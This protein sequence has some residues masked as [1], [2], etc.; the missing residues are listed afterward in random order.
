MVTNEANINKYK[1]F[2]L[3][4]CTQLFQLIDN[5]TENL[6]HSDVDIRMIEDMKNYLRNI[7]LDIEHLIKV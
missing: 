6:K 4:I 7:Y 1:Y 2:A 5:M 3:N